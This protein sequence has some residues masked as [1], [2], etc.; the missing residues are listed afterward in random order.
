MAQNFWT[1]IFAWSTCCAV[2]ILVSLLTARGVPVRDLSGLV[3]SQTKRL[4]DDAEPWYR[5]PVTLGV[6]ALAAV[7]CL[8]IVF[9]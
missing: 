7:A 9:W 2:T 4:T 6:L 1:A 3:Y 8:N 5:R